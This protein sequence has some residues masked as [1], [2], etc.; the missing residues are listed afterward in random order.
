SAAR[1]L[2]VQGP[3]R[4]PGPR[5]GGPDRHRGH[6][7]SGRRLVARRGR[8]PGHVSRSRARRAAARGRDARRAGGHRL[9]RSA[10]SPD[11]RVLRYPPC[12]GP[13]RPDLD[14]ARGA[15]R[16]RARRALV[17]DAGRRESRRDSR[18][19]AP[20][21]AHAGARDRGVSG[22][23]HFARHHRECQR[24][25][26]VIPGKPLLIVAAALALVALAAVFVDGATTPVRVLYGL[27]LAVAAVD[28]WLGWSIRAPTI[29]RTLA[30]SLSLAAWTHVK[31]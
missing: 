6:R 29:E 30:S 14:R 27:L 7:K 1:P 17:R 15:G 13:A 24:A 2:P 21:P 23:R 18:A 25:S 3:D 8:S 4:L 5:R 26:H 20:H 22:R 16:G 10:R 9:C 12:R 31:L 11:A 28:A 19:A